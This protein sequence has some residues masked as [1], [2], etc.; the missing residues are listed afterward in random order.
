MQFSRDIKYYEIYL[1][2]RALDPDEQP[3][4]EIRSYIDIDINVVRL[5][6]NVYSLT[7][8]D[9]FHL[10][11]SVFFFQ[12]DLHTESIERTFRILLGLFTIN[13]FLQVFCYQCF[14]CV[15]FKVITIFF[16]Y[17]LANLMIFQAT[18]VKLRR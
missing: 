15:C 4:E 6:S 3:D 10:L 12:D 9:D 11:A 18:G 5:L 16:R 8:T 2:R 1:G 14:P 13:T 17:V 7:I